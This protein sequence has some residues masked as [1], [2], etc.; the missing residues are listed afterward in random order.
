M[1]LRCIA[2]GAV[3]SVAYADI[4]GVVTGKPH[5]FPG[6]GGSV[7]YLLVQTRQQFRGEYGAM[8]IPV[9][10]LLTIGGGCAI[11]KPDDIGSCLVGVDAGGA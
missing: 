9:V 3:A 6:E 8:I 11:Y 7:V 4:A 2:G 1:A 10:D 5:E